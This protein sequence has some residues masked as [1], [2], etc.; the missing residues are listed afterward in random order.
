MEKRSFMSQTKLNINAFI[1]DANFFIILQHIKL[2][3]FIDRLVEIKE[4]LD[5]RFYISQ[6]V[7]KEIHLSEA[8]KQSFENLVK[9]T[10]VSNEEIH[11]VKRDLVNL[12]INESRHAQD[13][14]LSLISLSRKIRNPTTKVCIVSD[15]FKLNDN[16]KLLESIGSRNYDMEFWPLSAF[17]LYLTRMTKR[18][19]LQNYFKTARDKTLKNRLAYMLN[20]HVEKKYNVQNKLIWLIEKA[21]SV[22]E[23]GSFNLTGLKQSETQ[24][25]QILVNHPTSEELSVDSTDKASEIMH[26]CSK[27]IQKQK[28]SSVDLEKVAIMVPLLDE[29]IEGR[30]YI[31]IAKSLL[32]EDHDAIGSLR[33]AKDNLMYT[34][35]KAGS[36]LNPFHY[37][38]FQKLV[39]SEL[40]K[41][42]FLRAFL[43]IEIGDIYTALE[44]LDAT[45]MFSTMAQITNTVLS[46]NY[47]K[48]IVYLFNYMYIESIDQFYFTHNLAVN[49]S[50][51]PLLELKCQIGHAIAQ[52]LSGLQTEA[53]ES[54]DKISTDIEKGNLEDALIVFQELGDYFYAMS[55]PRI[56]ITLYDEALECAVDDAKLEWRIENILDKLK[57]AYMNA[58]LESST[59]IENPNIDLIINHVYELKNVNR[60]NQEIAKLSRFHQIFYED[61]PIYTQGTKKI[62]YFEIDEILRDSFDVVGILK[63]DKSQN[64]VLIVYNKE[65][66]LI[67]FRLNLMKKQLQGIPENYTIKLT[68]KA[69]VRILKPSNELKEKYLIRALICVDEPSHVEINRNIPVFFA[70]MNI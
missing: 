49:Y 70:E 61:F 56:A 5:V 14:D 20:Q 43:F 69:Y 63:D 39:C 6:Q 40:S 58:L 21:I 12:G 13:P 31:K 38:V 9:I 65:I 19:D 22:T 59:T 42:E 3:N 23:D 37:N 25:K 1:F 51:P 36:V 57:R 8:E 44:A 30:Q 24:N 64:T 29:M 15:D 50:A 48:A 66:G 68:K 35:Q 32:Q 16:V 52:F 33:T 34:L 26:I 28:I 41:C 55:N 18:V 60:Y 62:T 7:F 45:A 2:K 27:Y 53:L 67:G 10:T 17:L 46:I 4:E 47:L 11:L 54:I